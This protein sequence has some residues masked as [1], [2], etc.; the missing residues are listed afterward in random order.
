MNS[1]IAMV[2]SVSICGVTTILGTFVSEGG[3]KTELM[4]ATATIVVLSMIILFPHTIL[5]I[6]RRLRNATSRINTAFFV[7]QKQITPHRIWYNRVDKKPLT[8]IQERSYSD[9]YDTT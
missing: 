7:I 9:T 8:T 4:M 5:F 1:V 2:S 3:V 6:N